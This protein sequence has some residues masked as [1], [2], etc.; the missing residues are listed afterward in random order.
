[1]TK[2][3]RSSALTLCVLVA[4]P[5]AYAQTGTRAEAQTV[6][7]WTGKTV[8]AEAIQLSPG[9]WGYEV[10]VD[11]KRYI[12]QEMVPGIAGMHHFRNEADAVKVGA[13]AVSKMQAGTSP[14]SITADELRAL[15]VL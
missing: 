15:K 7:S 3:F 13:L 2:I 9:A 11:G 6:N 4:V 12:R 5:G 1:M 8:T 14:F 10:M